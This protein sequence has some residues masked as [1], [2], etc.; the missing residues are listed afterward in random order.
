MASNRPRY[1]GY[2]VHLAVSRIGRRHR[3]FLL[4]RHPAGRASCRRE[5][6][7]TVE[8]YDITYLNSRTVQ[9]PDRRESF[10]TLDVSQKRQAHH[11]PGSRAHLLSRL[12]HQR[13]PC[14]H[15][16]DAG[17]RPLRSPQRSARRRPQHRFPHF[18]KPPCL[19]DV[20]RGPHNDYR[21]RRGPLAFPKLS[22]STTTLVP[23]IRPS[24]QGS[25]PMN[26]T[27][28]PLTHFRHSCESRSLRRG[29]EGVPF[30]LFTLP[31]RWGKVW[32]GVIPPIAH[33]TTNLVPAK[34]GTHSLLANI[35]TLP[36]ISL[37]IPRSLTPC[38]T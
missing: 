28:I 13:H 10:F 33:K 32:M 26:F 25:R 14:R 27:L 5:Q 1:G 20:A 2:V 16:L 15:P 12:Q 31:A 30:P 11:H 3:R 4:L 36:G 22:A 8:G 6:T 34:A 17:G 19:V 23:D 29:V 38:T 18:R 37:R 9:Q 7:V 35:R 21:N 24:H